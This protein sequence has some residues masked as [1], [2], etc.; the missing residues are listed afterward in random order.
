L[1]VLLIFAGFIS[2]KG[3]VLGMWAGLCQIGLIG[4]LRCLGFVFLG[5]RN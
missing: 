3:N 5:I 2:K 4:R 1:A